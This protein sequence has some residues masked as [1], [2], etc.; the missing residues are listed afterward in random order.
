MEKLL[1][2]VAFSRILFKTLHLYNGGDGTMSLST[3]SMY[4]ELIEKQYGWSDQ[5]EYYSDE[6]NKEEKQ[7]QDDTSLKVQST[8]DSAQV[9]YL[10]HDS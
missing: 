6:I 2:N 4:F 1:D 7:R 9:Q 10:T 5:R 8:L 3:V